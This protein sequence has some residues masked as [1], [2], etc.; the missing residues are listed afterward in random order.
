MPAVA[1]TP[2]LNTQPL[3]PLWPTMDP[4]LFC[5]H[6]DDAYPPGNAELGPDAPLHGRQIG[7]D[8]SRR[9]GWSMYHGD[10][11]PGF[12]PHPHRGFETVTIVRKGLIDHADSLG[13]A[14]RFGQGDVQW[15]TA[16]DGVVHSEMFPL[17]DRTGP[18]PLE[19][20]QIWLNLPARSKRVDPHF[21]MFWSGDIPRVVDPGTDGAGATHVAVVAGRL[22]E[23][24]PLAPPPGS[25]AAQ[26]E[27][28]VAIWTLRLEPGARF[29]LPAATGEGTRRML[30]FFAGSG[31]TL[32][33][34][35]VDHAAVELRAGEAVALHNGGTAD[36]EFLLLQGRP[37]A[38]PVVQYGPFVMNTQQ[39]I[40]EAL[41]DYRRT[42]FGGW[43]WGDAAPVHGPTVGRFAQRPGTAPDVPAPVDVGLPSAG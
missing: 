1:D 18:N 31:V 37:L 8:F 35:P 34:R 25:W 26:A 42:G 7:Q 23:A 39:E 5:A 33:G 22:G 27:A 16:G 14:A 38:E 21:T 40:A 43:P 6:H 32:A 3:G 12:P 10:V 13:A 36:A 41:A 29:T 20:F 28:D 17:L 4:F 24:A 15:L 2:I 9:D 30:Y 11:V 19:L